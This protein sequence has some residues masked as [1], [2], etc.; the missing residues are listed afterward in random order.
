MEDFSCSPSQLQEAARRLRALASET[1]T[2]VHTTDP[3]D[4]ASHSAH[5]AVDATAAAL[6]RTA[7]QYLALE[8]ASE[9]L[10][11]TTLG[12]PG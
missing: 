10:I 11:R 3:L 4:R 7:Q 5:R 9:Q 8:A 12:T 2:T 6:E 1:D